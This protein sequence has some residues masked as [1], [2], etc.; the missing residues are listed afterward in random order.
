M[1]IRRKRDTRGSLSY[2]SQNYKTLILELPSARTPPGTPGK[3]ETNVGCA[4][5]SLC[6]RGVR[7]TAY[8]SA[9]ATESV[10]ASGSVV[11]RDGR[12][13][14]ERGT[15]QRET[16]DESAIAHPHS[17]V[18]GGKGGEWTTGGERGGCRNSMGRKRGENGTADDAGGREMRRRYGRGTRKGTTAG[19]PARVGMERS[20]VQRS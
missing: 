5:S 2:V 20:W 13:R 16:L 11:P 8:L 3:K 12:L 6:S 17:P 9:R 18:K 1:Q 15:T 14:R 4:L 10:S 19:S 7:Q